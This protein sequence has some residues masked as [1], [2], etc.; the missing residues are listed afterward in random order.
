MLG[1][2]KSIKPLK[3]SFRQYKD[4]EVIALFFDLKDMVGDIKVY[5]LEGKHESADLN[6][7]MSL[8]TSNVDEAKKLQ[9]VKELEDQGCKLAIV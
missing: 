4:G 2:T 7:V 8:T 3:V 6:I 5:T 1:K 9:L